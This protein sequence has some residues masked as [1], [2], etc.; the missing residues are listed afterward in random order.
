MEWRTN[1]NTNWANRTCDS[2]CAKFVCKG[3]FGDA[4]GLTGQRLPFV[5]LCGSVISSGRV[6]LRVLTNFDVGLRRDDTSVNG[7]FMFGVTR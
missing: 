2:F 7:V 5:V 3:G 1:A 6:T 4:Y